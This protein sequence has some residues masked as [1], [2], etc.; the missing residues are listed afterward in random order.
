MIRTGLVSITFR[1]LA[2]EAI[3]DLARQSG[4]EGIEWGGDVHVPHGDLAQA[5]AVRKMTAQSGLCACSYGSYY[6]PGARQAENPDPQAVLQ[7]ARSLGAPRVRL[8]AG[9]TPS[10]EA[11]PDDRQAVREQTLALAG[12]AHQAGLEVGFEYHRNTLTDQ[13]ASARQLYSELAAAGPVAW[14]QP[15]PDWPH[16]DRLESLL[17]LR[18]RLAVVHVFQ[19]SQTPEGL[20]RNPLA[21]G[22]G[23]WRDYL[24]AAAATRREVWALLEFVRGNE[25]DQLLR[26]ATVLQELVDEANSA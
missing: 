12:P 6:R 25:P 3:I 17:A 1:E 19:W 15:R 13:N 23:E 10:A 7:T 5:E 2:P 11:G 16:N 24:K 9:D 20:T 4:L 14:W 18:D 8:W 26:D 21:D 22:R